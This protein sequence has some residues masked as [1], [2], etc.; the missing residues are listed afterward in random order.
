L[1]DR[2]DIGSRL[3]NWARLYTQHRGVQQEER[4]AFDQ[5]DAQL[6][7]RAMPGMPTMQRSLLWWCYVKQETPEGACLM[8]GIANKPAVQF[9][10]AFRLAQDTIEVLAAGQNH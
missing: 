9:V 2:R 7:E 8:L 1:T 6:L 3:E 5:V 10:A 4:R